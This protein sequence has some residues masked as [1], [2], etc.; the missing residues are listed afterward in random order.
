MYL[1]Y[2]FYELVCSGLRKRGDEEEKKR[3]EQKELVCASAAHLSMGDDYEMTDMRYDNT[4][5]LA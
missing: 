3:R 5:F 2:I 4:L 1:F